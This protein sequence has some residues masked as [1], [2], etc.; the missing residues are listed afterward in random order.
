MSR[1]SK[2]IELGLALILLSVIALLVFFHFGA[3]G[4]LIPNLQNIVD[5]L[6]A[7]GIV[8]GIGLIYHSGRRTKNASQLAT[9][10][11]KPPSDDKEKSR[12]RLEAIT[13]DILSPDS[14]R[15]AVRT[16]LE[17]PPPEPNEEQALE[18][19][20]RKMHDN[21]TKLK[22]LDPKKHPQTVTDELDKLYFVIN[23]LPYPSVIQWDDETRAV[24]SELLDYI[25]SLLPPRWIG[26]EERCFNW[27]NLL[28]MR[29]DKGTHELLKT[30]FLRTISVLMN[31]FRFEKNLVP[32][33]L[34]QNLNDYS[35]DPMM[36]LVKAALG[37][38]RAAIG[39]QWSD[40][41]F[42]V[43]YL[44]IAF[45][46]MKAKNPQGLQTLVNFLFEE[47]KN[48]DLNDLVRYKKATLLLGRAEAAL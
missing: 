19:W 16:I 39:D 21:L 35:T 41:R 34:Y 47:K 1:F 48:S 44:H 17:P 11:D 9:P 7:A 6:V 25:E 12:K 32:L 8:S 26:Y 2:E 43:M 3:I 31:D 24:I 18:N 28:N 14:L 42:S 40:E 30:R 46:E 27:I 36:D 20:K 38:G 4:G 13:D 22:S 37:E 45:G 23:G 33:S 29:N 5:I 10:S 15:N